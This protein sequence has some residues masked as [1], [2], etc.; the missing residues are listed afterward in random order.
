MSN[1]HCNELDAT[2]LDVYMIQICRFYY[3][4]K[5]VNHMKSLFESLYRMAEVSLEVEKK[6]TEQQRNQFRAQAKRFVDSVVA[7]INDCNE[8]KIEVPHDDAQSFTL[9]SLQMRKKQ[10]DQLADAFLKFSHGKHSMYDLASQLEGLRNVEEKQTKTVCFEK[11]GDIVFG[12]LLSL[13][14]LEY[15]YVRG[16]QGELY[17]EMNKAHSKVALRH[18]ISRQFAEFD[19]AIFRFYCEEPVDRYKDF[20][21]YSDVCGNNKDIYLSAK[22]QFHNGG[23]SLKEDQI[24]LPSMIENRTGVQPCME[25]PP[26]DLWKFGDRLVHLPSILDD[27]RQSLNQ[28][29]SNRPKPHPIAKMEELLT[30]NAASWAQFV[31]ALKDRLMKDS[32][33]VVDVTI[34]ILFEFSH[35]IFNS[36]AG[37][38]QTNPNHAALK[39]YFETIARRYEE[40]RRDPQSVYFKHVV[41]ADRQVPA[42]DWSQRFIFIISEFCRFKLYNKPNKRDAATGYDGYWTHNKEDFS[43][44]EGLLIEYSAIETEKEQVVRQGDQGFYK[45]TILNKLSE[46]GQKISAYDKDT[47]PQFFEKPIEDF[48]RALAK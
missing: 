2:A 29:D 7:I 42:D 35:F 23:A 15:R 39:S 46:I 14:F 44:F 24:I 3:L 12:L 34:Y 36:I 18:T 47:K 38:E 30:K 43:E 10:K 21:G 13:Y 8:G 5:G 1:K 11:L 6:F 25:F 32:K 9:A 41:G 27:L 22:Y 40:A 28:S 17:I 45:L 4:T 19:T 20:T 37:L 31:T 33:R 48:A 16:L 26:Y